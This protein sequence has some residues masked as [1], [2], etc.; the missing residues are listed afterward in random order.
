ML[1]VSKWKD[2]VYNYS[3]M[4]GFGDVWALTSCLLKISEHIKKPVRFFSVSKYLN[5]LIKLISLF[6]ISR[7]KIQFVYQYPQVVFDYCEPFLYNLKR[8]CNKWRYNKSKIVAYQFDGRHLSYE[9]NLPPK[10]LTFL[11]ESLIKLGYTPVNIGEKKPISF[12]VNTLAK[13]EFFI[14]CPSGMSVVCSSVGTP[15][16]LITRQ[17]PSDYLGFLRTCQYRR[18]NVF[19]YRTVNEFLVWAKRHRYLADRRKGMGETAIV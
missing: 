1:K 13:C 7:G 17:I 11:L 15:I 2:R 3:E 12:I 10:R 5:D 18:A 16:H 14:G 19:M 9:K 6:L 4:C 8:T